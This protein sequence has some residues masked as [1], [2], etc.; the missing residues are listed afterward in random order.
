MGTNVARISFVG[1][2]REVAD[3]EGGTPRLRRSRLGRFFLCVSYRLCYIFP[4][5]SMAMTC[6]FQGF[7]LSLDFNAVVFAVPP[8]SCGTS[9]GWES[10]FPEPGGELLIGLLEGPSNASKPS[11]S[12]YDQL[13]DLKL[14]QD[15]TGKAT[16]T[17]LR[18]CEPCR[19]HCG[20]PYCKLTSR[21]VFFFF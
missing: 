4:I 15:S 8:R 14:T 5:W 9:W 3:V 13:A 7:R 21:G 12:Q 20:P 10:L 1:A 6:N 18:V 16:T 2:E 17:T 19:C 11:G